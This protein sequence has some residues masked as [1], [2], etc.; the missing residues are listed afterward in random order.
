M[1]IITKADSTLQKI[2]PDGRKGNK[3]SGYYVTP[4]KVGNRFVFV[5][6]EG[7]EVSY[8]ETSKIESIFTTG[9]GYLI[10]TA[11]SVYIVK[12]EPSDTTTA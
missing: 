1:K 8:L 5:Y 3:I 12:E 6:G 10:R 4:P 2:E 7:T 11:N 9:A